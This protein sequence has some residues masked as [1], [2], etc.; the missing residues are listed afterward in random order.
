MNNAAAPTDGSSPST[1]RLPSVDR[2]SLLGGAAIALHVGIMVCFAGRW[3]AT[4]ALTIIPIWAWSLLG[5][6]LSAAARLAARSREASV[7]GALWL[8]T[9]LLAPDEW[10]GLRRA[11]IR[12]TPPP[13][14]ARAATPADTLRVVTHNCRAGNI[15]A[16]RQAASWNPDVLLLQETR[17]HLAGP[18]GALGRTLWGDDASLLFGHDTA[19][20]ARGRLTPSTRPVAPGVAHQFLQATL[21]LPDG[22]TLEIASVHLQG[23]VTDLRLWKPQLWRAHARNQQRH[24]T[25]LDAIARSC[26]DSATDR[27][28]LIGGDFNSPANDRAF[29]ALKPRFLDAFTTAG[30][31]WG[32]TFRNDWPVLRIDQVWATP[33]LIPHSARAVTASHSDHRFVVVDYVWLRERAGER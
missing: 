11:V 17:A 4:A 13:A 9:L 8:A 29:H 33:D 28:C 14:P 18:L 16:A 26:L 22:R 5:L 24:R 19:I 20:L 1:S 32:N 31:G 30:V 15:Q 3:D 6:T 7:A 23:H 12:T 2:V 21:T 10:H 25:A 27:P